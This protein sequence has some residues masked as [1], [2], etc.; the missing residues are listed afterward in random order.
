MFR[1]V[2]LT[3][4]SLLRAL[5][6]LGVL[7]WSAASPQQADPLPSW[8]DTAPKQAIA[9]FVERV[10]QDGGPDYI[11]PAKRIAVFDNDGTLWAEQPIYFQF[12]F[13]IDRVKQLAPEHPEWK[14]T[15]PFKG[16]LEG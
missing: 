15:Q 5:V 13:A 14:D 1:I 11:E 2:D 4:R 16:I 8:N 7:G 6:A 3:R 12:Q 9:A 10:T